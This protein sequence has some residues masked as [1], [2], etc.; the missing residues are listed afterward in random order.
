MA[1]GSEKSGSL[2]KKV[3]DP[4]QNHERKSPAKDFYFFEDFIGTNFACLNRPA[5]KDAWD[6]FTKRF[7]EEG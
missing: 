2:E 7:T 4:Q 1:L 3:P 6:V 5:Q